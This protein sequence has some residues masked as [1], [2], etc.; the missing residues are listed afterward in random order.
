MAERFVG[1]VDFGGREGGGVLLVGGRELGFVTEL[2]TEPGVTSRGPLGLGN[3]FALLSRGILGLG[4]GEAVVGGVA[5]ASDLLDCDCWLIILIVL[6]VLIVLYVFIVLK[7]FMVLLLLITLAL[8]LL[9]VVA[10]LAEPLEPV[11][12]AGTD[13][14]VGLVGV[15]FLSRAKWEGSKG[16]ALALN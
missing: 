4:V 9:G 16:A 1:E 14:L 11:R 6:I 12:P 7:V 2:C 15:G 5:V 8:L 13:A 10:G 3:E